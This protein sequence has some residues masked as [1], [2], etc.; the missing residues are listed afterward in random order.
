M[1]FGGS[2]GKAVFL[3]LVPDHHQAIGVGIRKRAQEQGV[4]DAEDRGICADPERER[5]HGGK[6][7]AWGSEEA[8]ES[9]AEVVQH[10]RL[11]LFSECV[12]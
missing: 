9:V 2:A 4:D 8:S 12:G 3:E 6:R 5:K 10:W 1:V 7:E 11:L